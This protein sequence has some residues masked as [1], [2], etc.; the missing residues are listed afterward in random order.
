MAGENVVDIRVTSTD[1]TAAGFGEAKAGAEDTAAAFDEFAAAQE[2]AQEASAELAEASARLAEVQKD[3]SA[4]A[5]D[6]AG[7]QDAY[8]A[9]LERNT[10][11]TLAS[12]D[13]QARLG[14]AE[15]AQAGSAKVAG[16]ASEVAGEKAEASSGVAA[17]AGGRLKMAL[18]GVAIGAGLAIKGAADYQAET[19]R[20]VT[21]AGESARNLGLVRQGMLNLSS[22][23]DS[24]LSDL[25]KGMYLV[26][27]AG[28]HGAA[29]LTVLRAAAEGAK[30]ENADLGT[31][32]NALTSILNAYHM[33]AEDATA[34]TNQ[35]LAAVGRGKMTMEDFSS[36]LSAVLPI[37]SSAHVSFDQVGGAI[38][39]MTAQGM[40]TRQASQDLANM[41]RSLVSPSQTASQEMKALGLNANDVSKDVG[42]EGLTGTLGTLT[43]AILKNTQGGDVLI[44]YMH[45]MTP[46]AQGLAQ[47]ILAGTISTQQLRT[48]VYNLNPEQAKLISLFEA[49]ATSATG[50]RQTFD[51]AMAKM[52][53]GAT[54]LNVALMLG[55]KHMSTFESNTKA[56]GEAGS[57]AGKD[58]N[59]WS[60]IQ[61]E[62]DFQMGSA[63]KAV[64]AMG[65]QLGTAL[66][67]AVSAVMKPIAA[68]AGLI[69][70]N[71]IAADAFALVVG[72]VLAA[73][74][75][76]KLVG[77]FSSMKTAVTEVGSG[78]EWLLGKLGLVAGETEGV[79]AATDAEAVATDGATAAMVE[80]DAAADSNP[81][82]LIAL[83]IEA[84]IVA[85]IAL[86]VGIYEL[87]KHW[88]G[89]ATAGVDTWHFINTAARDTLGAIEAVARPVID[90][91]A[92]AW[93]TVS[94]G[95]SEA[96]GDVSSDIGAAVG[97]IEGIW[98]PIWADL[99]LPFK[100]ADDIIHGHISAIKGQVESAVEGMG[101]MWRGL[102]RDADE[103]VT[104]IEHVFEAGWADIVSV[105][106][107]AWNDTVETV[108]QAWHDI[109]AW[110]QDGMNRA[111]EILSWLE[112][113]P[114]FFAREFE[115]AGLAGW[116]RLL[117]F[118]SL[119]ASLPGR[120][121]H[122]I[123]DLGH[124]LWSA[125]EQIIQ[126]LIG[127]IESAAGGLLS[128]VEGLAK[129]VEGAFKD[130]LSILSPSR[131][132][133]EHGRN[134]VLGAQMGVEAEGPRL[135]A[136]VRR[137]ARDASGAF[138]PGYGGGLALAGSGAA[139]GGPGGA[140]V[141]LEVLLSA[142]PGAN[143]ELV[144]GL[145]PY[146]RAEV[147]VVG[148]G[149]PDS[150][151]KAL[152][153][154]A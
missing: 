4:S 2:K 47:Q 45:E 22:A 78:V 34:V 121:I 54:G 111:K 44:G 31:V 103:A 14:E 118:L 133:F 116:N 127:G 7:A 17:E 150:A 108:E 37:A 134:I 40:S 102:A 140:P 62:F 143:G 72:G 75:G 38:A 55:G 16:D 148:G 106:Q 124:L 88:R 71:K 84:I 65:V 126:G 142:A 57:K 115:Q 8:S 123:G 149:G 113:L 13:A 146:L 86:G 91:L 76:T 125:G 60:A 1:M 130:V 99:T 77:A 129:D 6:V 74:L 64:E 28:F 105:A 68:L 52:T 49:S 89:L 96:F 135:L 33:K 137:L 83:A 94:D 92:S 104:D 70:R 110:I 32:S 51:G 56:V 39:T 119:V 12:L 120:I 112:S 36:A 9:A 80:F 66:L 90:W 63:E 97:F 35:M 95:V 19:E 139:Y 11:A 50:L 136:S 152:G 3:G 93:H 79:A 69:A 87:I 18:L 81:I 107:S 145:M 98:R 24:S 21:S 30:A 147:R 132:F 67:P 117:A 128:E 15:L 144:R 85:L 141:R 59:N 42:S 27:S 20:L 100:I 154:V 29:G 26:E 53:G 101:K 46:A 5:E 131:V 43:D 151:Q 153:R 82:G 73:A 10:E 58:I 23:T 122:E 25:S 138:A 114:G 41:I 48:A 109:G 61:H